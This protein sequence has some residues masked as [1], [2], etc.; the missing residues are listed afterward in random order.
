[1][2]VMEN[3]GVQKTDVH[4]KTFHGRLKRVYKTTEFDDPANRKIIKALMPEYESYVE[5]TRQVRSQIT[6]GMPDYL[7]A[8][9]DQPLLSREQ[10]YHQFRK[11]NY[12]KFLAQKWIELD[13]H[14]KASNELVRADE[15]R[16]LITSANLRLVIKIVKKFHSVRHHEDLV[17]ES[18]YLIHRAVDYF[19]YTRG[20]KFSTYA[21]WAV[22][23][24]IGRTANDLFKH[25]AFHSGELESASLNL[26]S[27]EVEKI[28]EQ[29]DHFKALVEN[30]LSVAKGR[31]KEILQRRFFHGETLNNIAQDLNITK[32]RVRQIESKGL[33]R[34]A[35]YAA[36]LGLTKEKVF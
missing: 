18:Y 2:E 28:K 21:T 27:A 23:N 10:E 12:F 35:Q 25:D 6:K 32:E 19:D 13:Q 16:A 7:R 24:T 26:V 22:Q 15:V 11:Y 30:L 34:L 17:S 33:E 9:Y 29:D 4:Q 31:E 1:M 20:F 8:C 3:T 14:S 36:R 5:K